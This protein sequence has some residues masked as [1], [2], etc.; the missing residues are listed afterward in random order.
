MSHR[1][2]E[3][4][5]GSKFLLVKIPKGDT[6]VFNLSAADI[7]AS[8]AGAVNM[9]TIRSY[10]VNDDFYYIL[11]TPF[12]IFAKGERAEGVIWPPTMPLVEVL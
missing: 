9:S 2:D 5:K 10:A 6:D 7:V 4:W 11:C 12:R 3:E 1:H 8:F